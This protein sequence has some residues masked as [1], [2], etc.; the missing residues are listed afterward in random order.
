MN[1][2]GDWH[3]VACLAMVCALG[4]ADRAL[5]GAVDIDAFATTA[6]WTVIASDGVDASIEP[7]DGARDGRAMRIRYKFSGGGFCVVRRAV[8]LTLGDNYRFAFDVRGDGPPNNLEFKL[9]DPSGDNVWWVN[10]RRF[11]PPA[12]WTRVEYK[13]RHFSFAW[14]PAGPTPLRSVGAIEFAIAAAEGGEGYLDIDG[15]TFEP[16]P[17]ARPLPE[18]MAVNVSSGN[19]NSPDQISTAGGAIQ[20]HSDAGDAAPH[21]TL[22][23]SGAREFGGLT[24]SWGAD[25]FAT[26]YDVSLSPDGRAWSPVVRIRGGDG[27]TDFLPIPDA[28]AAFIR[29]DVRDDNADRGVAID[30]VSVEPIEFGSSRNAMFRA[31]AKR[32]PRGWYPRYCYLQQPYWTIVGMAGDDKELLIDTDGAIEVDQLGFRVEPFLWVDG[33]LISWADVNTSTTLAEGDLPIPT[34]TWKTR[35][36]LALAITVFTNGEPGAARGCVRYRVTNEG[37]QPI[38]GALFLAVRPFQVLPPWQDLNITGGSTP[39]GSIELRD[40]IIRVDGKPWIAGWKTPDGFA[41][42]GYSQGSIVERIARGSLP[43]RT[44]VTDPF[45]LASAAMRYDFQLE[46]GETTNEY[47]SIAMHG[48][49][50][51]QASND[52]ADRWYES[53]FAAVREQ[54]REAI[55]RVRLSLPPSARRIADTFRTTQA[56]V[57]INADG[58]AI[59]PGSRTYARSWIRDGAMTSTALHVTGHHKQARAFLDWYSSYLF[60]SGKVPCVVDHRGADPVDEHDSNG[61][62][63]YALMTDF[64]FT[65]DAAFLRSHVDQLESAVGYIK[66]LRAKRMTDEYRH[67]DGVK[68]AYYGL[69]PESISHEGYS[70]KP[71]HSYWDD[72]FLMKG[73]S[74]AV[75]AA[76]VLNRRDLLARFAVL[77]NSFR[78][79][80]YASM[81]LAMTHHGIGYIPG[82]V[83]LGDFDATSTAIG[84][85]P[86][87]QLRHMPQPQLQNTFDRYYEFFTKRRD[88]QL[89]WTN[90]T[91]YEIR[92][93]GTFV[94]LNQPQR[95]HQLLKYFMADQRP[96]GWNHWAEVVWRDPATPRFI[97]DMPHTWVGGAFIN[98]IRAMFVY[99]DGDR[100]ILLAGIDPAWVEEA[101]GV[102]LEGFPTFFGTLDISGRVDDGDW[103][104]TIGGSA[105]PPDGAVLHMPSDRG[106]SRVEVDGKVVELADGGSR[107]K[108]DRMP[109]EVRI[110]WADSPD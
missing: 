29:I 100:L 88:G 22:D 47:V 68:R 58:P 75:D 83:E 60:D 77:R 19:A 5:G 94:R 80:L 23:L 50:L 43:D 2:L 97:G 106:I 71:M 92:L 67:A 65:R 40:R 109:R 104:I 63:I 16:L 24:L 91:P 39:I 61:E 86:C 14:G 90:Y 6:G 3:Q 15:L 45:E 48:Q 53:R 32:Q 17:E 70:A 95:A 30:A 89:E 105:D 36:D 52:N 84:L 102:K 78:E 28:E 66:S 35:G 108:L 101:D 31:I 110:R 55:N 27:E 11:R 51:D 4:H 20:W 87:D 13:R 44:S 56:Y 10:R 57:L 72:L 9:V 54:W 26:N 37:D 46:P 98:A 21:M 64:R 85:F 82:C 7:C 59:Q 79:T 42:A 107:F 74:D 99:E 103:L 34:V 1:R 96:V 41:A 12:D 25:D 8:D 73:L 49:Q 69:A 38:G 93:I 18:T 81:R 62:Y 33:K 76:N